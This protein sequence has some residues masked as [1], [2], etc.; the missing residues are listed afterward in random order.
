MNIPS[1][2]F[3][4]SASLLAIKKPRSMPNAMMTPYHLRSIGPRETIT[5]S[6]GC[7]LNIIIQSSVDFDL[8]VQTFIEFCRCIIS[9]ILQ[10]V[11]H[12]CDLYDAGETPALTDRQRY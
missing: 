2:M 10:T 11:I 12:R 9:H 4:L 7:I 5:G 3:F 6:S 1:G 8:I